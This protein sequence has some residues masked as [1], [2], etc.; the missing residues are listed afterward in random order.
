MKTCFGPALASVALLLS[1]CDN[2][3][4]G[5]RLHLPKGS[6]ENGKTAFIA[7]KCTDCHTV[8]G[9]EL[10][11]PTAAPENIVQLGGDVPRLRT[12]GDLL[13]SIIHPTQS[14]PLTSQ[15]AAP[16]P[17]R[18]SMP[19]VNEKMTVAQMVDLVRF[20]QPHYSEM[21]PPIDWTYYSL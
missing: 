3:E 5:R 19:N 7:L 13:T 2:L 15:G 14:I 11:K 8:S 21:E 20:L 10:P 1:A 16:T 12:V 17:D 6:A 9:V 4:S 18:S